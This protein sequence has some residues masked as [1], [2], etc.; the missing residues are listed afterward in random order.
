MNMAGLGM[1]K[2]TISEKYYLGNNDIKTY[3]I[4]NHVLYVKEW[5]FAY[6]RSLKMLWIPSSIK[7]IHPTAFDGCGSLE[8]V[9]VYE[10]MEREPSFIYEN[11]AKLLAYGIRNF[12][13]YPNIYDFKDYGSKLWYKKYDTMLFQY[14]KEADDTGFDPFLAGG[15]EDY[16]DPDSHIE[17]YRYKRQKEKIYGILIRLEAGVNTQI[18][19]SLFR[20]IQKKEG[21]LIEVLKE[22]REA[23]VT[24]IKILDSCNYFTKE[25]IDLFLNE[26]EG[27]IYTESRAYLLGKKE[28]LQY[29]IKD[30]WN[31]Y[32]L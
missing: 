8:R 3:R 5:A 4:D 16:E 21:L 18:M 24:Y 11:E 19:Q 32:T 14:L 28:A 13:E 7:E 20:Y 17:V 22:M 30:V 15:E 2:D 1:E 26:F 27:A 12:R 29:E 6:C 23:S 25:N 31:S 10:G 9:Y